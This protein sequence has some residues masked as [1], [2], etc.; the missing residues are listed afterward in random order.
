MPANWPSP[1]PLGAGRRR[2]GSGHV[3]LWARIKRSS[4]ATAKTANTRPEPRRSA[5][6]Q[7]RHM[8]VLARP[9][10]PKTDWMEEMD[11]TEGTCDGRFGVA[12]NSW[13]VP[14][15]LS[16]DLALGGSCFGAL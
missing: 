5:A 2:A 11:S 1:G 16:L 6:E 7:Q 4:I 8:A 14:H 9:R 10:M 15:S 12:N 13:E 3:L